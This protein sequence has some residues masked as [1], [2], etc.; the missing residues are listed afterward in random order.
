MPSFPLAFP[1]LLSLKLVGTLIFSPPGIAYSRMA[2]ES[3][4]VQA[5]V[6]S[7]PIAEKL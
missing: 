1:G 3:N 5:I 6:Y 4:V 2:V 7:L